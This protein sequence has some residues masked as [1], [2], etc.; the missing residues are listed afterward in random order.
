M[1]DPTDPTIVESNYPKEVWELLQS[2]KVCEHDEL[3]LCPKRLKVLAMLLKVKP[4][5]GGMQP[6]DELDQDYQSGR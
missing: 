5:L 3:Y 4:E 6:K 2:G 1:D